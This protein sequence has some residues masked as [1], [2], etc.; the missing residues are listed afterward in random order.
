[1]KISKVQK[2]CYEESKHMIRKEIQMNIIDIFGFPLKILSH[3]GL[4]V[5]QQ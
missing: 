2:G 5:F 4:N 3:S 1:M